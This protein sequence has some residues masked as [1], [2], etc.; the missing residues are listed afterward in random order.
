MAFD[1]FV[2]PRTSNLG[3]LP[4]KDL[5]QSRF[6]GLFKSNNKSKNQTLKKR[7]CCASL[8]GLAMAVILS[9]CGLPKSG[10]SQAQVTSFIQSQADGAAY[11]EISEQVAS[12]VSLESK[13]RVPSWLSEQLI[14]NTD[15]VRPG[16]TLNV[17]VHENTDATLLS[18]GV[19]PG[20]IVDVTV[21]N[22]GLVYLPYVGRVL[23][24]GKT[25]EQV[26]RLIER[27]LIPQTP[28]PQVV[29]RRVSGPASSVSI[30]GDVA[31]PGIFPLDISTRNLSTLIASAG[32]LSVRP[33]FAEISVFRGS[34]SATISAQDLFTGAIVD[35]AL[36]PNDRIFVDENERQFVGLG[37]LGQQSLVP[38][39]DGVSLIEAVALIGGLNP[40]QANPAGVFVFRM[41]D[42]KVLERVGL[43]TDQVG[44][45]KTVYALDLSDP[46]SFYL[47]SNF[48][49]RDDD[50]IYVT[51]AAFATTSKVLQVFTGTA[52]SL[53][54]V[55]ALSNE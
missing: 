37:A 53:G 31:T 52:G 49:V 34:R 41:E 36:V 43:E 25:T 28:D 13:S 24:S 7:T 1:D 40:S 16:D 17:T 9:G 11:L 26:R 35:V 51:E 5:V 21:A 4:E 48:Q 20:E 46:N 29:V 39:E 23:A 19:G 18:Y 12:A 6:F 38:F 14:F 22:D 42:A 45:T 27:K 10:P 33:E 3:T 2:R 30:L 54:S 47:A 55:R 50:V 8:T 15:T 44:F 32:G